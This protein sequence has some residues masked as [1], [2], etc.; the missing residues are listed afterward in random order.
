M[1][2][3]SHI[4]FSWILNLNTFISVLGRVHA[5]N[6]ISV[7]F[8][9]GR[10]IGVLG[11]NGAGK[12][13]LMKILSGYQ[14]AT[15]GEVCING[16]VVDYIGPLAAISAGIGMLQQDP[17]DVGAFTVLENFAYGLRKSLVINRRQ[18]RKILQEIIGRLGFDL[19][20]DSPIESL[21]VARRQQLE[22]ARLLALG[23]QTL[24][25]DEP[26]TGI[27]QEQKEILFRALKDLVEQDR[28]TVLLVSH[29]LED[30]IALCDEVIVLR[31]G[32]LIGTREMPATTEGLVTM[33][34]GQQLDRYERETVQIGD[35]VL[36]LKDVRLRTKRLEMNDISFQ[37]HAGELSVWR[38]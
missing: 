10:I 30:V 6:D 4:I 29:K 25:L 14:P 15:S 37:L 7:R 22:I 38:V 20:P 13:T 5:N 8:D 31:A 21:T 34:F 19:D 23:I 36:E 18:A 17:L 32:Q 2:S 9:E 35:P 33:M 27:S 16:A 12:S 24:I 26:T 3:L 11:E 1:S 28:M